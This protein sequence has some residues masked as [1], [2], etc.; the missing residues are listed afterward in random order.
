MKHGALRLWYF[1]TKDQKLL[2]KKMQ[3]TVMEEFVKKI[4]S[5]EKRSQLGIAL[6]VIT[7][8]N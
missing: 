3:T 8:D 6:Q 1:S 4:K 7:F 2:K 5:F